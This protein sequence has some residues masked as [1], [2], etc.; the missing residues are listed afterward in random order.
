VDAAARWEAAL[1]GWGF[2]AHVLEA[3]PQDPWRIDPSELPAG[4]S[5]DHRG[6]EPSQADALAREAL[7][8]RGSVLD[9]GCGPGGS[10]VHLRGRASRFTGVDANPRMLAEY[11]ATLTSRRPGLRG[12]LGTAPDV[13]TVEGVW[14]D[15]AEQVPAHDVVV[16]HNT[17]YNVNERVARFVEELTTHARRRVVLVVTERHPLSWLTP[18]VEQLH[19]L[20]RPSEPTAGTA[21]DVVRQVTGHA[22]VRRSWTV[23]RPVPDDEEQ[24]VRLVAR[25]CAVGEDRFDDVRTALRRVPPARTTRFVALAWPGGG[26][27]R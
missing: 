5:T 16:C 22:P 24:L 23:Q 17:L 15:V 8:R 10:S 14:P 12:L 19:G 7:P 6:T 18:Y 2:P 20:V 25:R 1:G 9:V 13:A 21:E 11:E 26:A 27:S 3:A 4:R